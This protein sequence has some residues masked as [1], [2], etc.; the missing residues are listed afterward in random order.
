MVNFVIRGKGMLENDQNK[1]V[2]MK[3]TAT[4]RKDLPL[5]FLRM[6]DME[7]INELKDKSPPKLKFNHK[8]G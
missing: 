7:E 4:E 1:G 8:E 6:L 2:E 5:R 3:A